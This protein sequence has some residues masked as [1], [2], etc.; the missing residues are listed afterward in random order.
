MIIIDRADLYTRF[1]RFQL[2]LFLL[3]TIFKQFQ[4]H[5]TYILF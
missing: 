2:S 3:Q 5:A 1:N 4:S